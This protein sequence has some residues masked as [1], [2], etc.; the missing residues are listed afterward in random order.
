MKATDLTKSLKKYSS[1]WV[2]INE[3]NNTVVAHA[4]DFQLLTKK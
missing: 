3:T 4:K 1:G 2:A